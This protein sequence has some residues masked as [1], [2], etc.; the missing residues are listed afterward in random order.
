MRRLEKKVAIVAGAGSGIGEATARLMAR[1]GASVV[2]ADINGTERSFHS[3][4]AAAIMA[5][6]C[7][8]PSVWSPTTSA[9]SSSRTAAPVDEETAV[10]SCVVACL[11]VRGGRCFQCR[12]VRGRECAG[13]CRGRAGDQPQ[14]ERRLRRRGEAE[15]P[16]RALD[17]AGAFDEDAGG[18]L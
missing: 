17:S 16:D 6:R 12:G 2:V 9:R 1:E 13:G 3:K 5:T 18:P 8:R 10:A 7:E 4:A 11:R 15:V 14:R